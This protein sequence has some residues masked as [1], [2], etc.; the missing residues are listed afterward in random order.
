M[1]AGHG[2][3]FLLAAVFAAGC[4]GNQAGRAPGAAAGGWIAQK[5]AGYSLEAPRGWTVR[6]EPKTGR[7]E[8]QGT[9]GEQ[10]VVWPVFLPG[11]LEAASAPAVLRKL[12]AG[13]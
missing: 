9:A 6:A 1:K 7:I 8:V 11:T 12:S 10:V 3:L 5:G 13:V 4:G 2:V